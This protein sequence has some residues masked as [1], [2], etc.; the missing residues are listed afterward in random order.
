MLINNLP[1]FAKW[2]RPAKAK[3]EGTNV[4]SPHF[5]HWEPPKIRSNDR[6]LLTPSDHS[7]RDYEEKLKF[8]L[9]RGK[10]R[11]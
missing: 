5:V 9:I 11:K 6:R 3:N 1:K 10:F 4:Y 2:I 7:E 8:D